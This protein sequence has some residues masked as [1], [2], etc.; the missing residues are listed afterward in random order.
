MRFRNFRSFTENPRRLAIA[1]VLFLGVADGCQSANKETA[2]PVPGGIQ[3]FH[4]QEPPETSD[5]VFVDID[6][7]EIR[8][9]QRSQ[10]D[11]MAVA[12]AR[13]VN[14]NVAYIQITHESQDEILFTATAFRTN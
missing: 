11:K 3:V 7:F 4:G 8:A 1:A 9:W 13:S 10:I 6:E 2:V 14:A 5:F 12:Y